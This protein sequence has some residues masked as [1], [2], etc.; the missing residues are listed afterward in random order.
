MIPRKSTTDIIIHCSAT[1]PSQ[2]IGFDEIDSWHKKRGWTG[3][4]YH[5]IIRR[6]GSIEFG[7]N[8]KEAGAH[9]KGYNDKSVGIVM[10][11]GISEDG[12]PE[13]NFTPEQFVTLEVS[14]RYYKAAY[15]DAN[16]GGH[17]DY[18]P[19]L[20]GDGIIEK[21]EWLKECPC[22]EVSNFINRIGL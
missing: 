5:D 14:L 20:D 16:I 22:F 1:K 17:R 9:V 12:K 3:C 7:R 2:D 8:R 15:P 10:V 11:G 4:G 6:D 19:D 18:S 21:H 13:N